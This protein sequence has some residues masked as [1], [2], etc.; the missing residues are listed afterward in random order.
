MQFSKVRLKTAIVLTIS[1]NI[2]PTVMQSI[3]SFIKI[4][5]ND[6]FLS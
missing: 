1:F 2:S 5:K 6:N 3:L 4:H